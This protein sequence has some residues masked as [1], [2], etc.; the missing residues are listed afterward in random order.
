M[1][2]LRA[3]GR[4]CYDFVV[5]DDWRIAAVVL[6]ALAGVALLAGT[7]TASWWLVPLAVALVLVESVYRAS[8]SHPGP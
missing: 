3:F 1:S 8:R 6:A 7:G 2:R 5:G 4:F